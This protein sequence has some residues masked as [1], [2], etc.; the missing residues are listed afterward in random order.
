MVNKVTAAKPKGWRSV[1]FDAVQRFDEPGGRGPEDAAIFG[2][3][4]IA[5][6]RRAFDLSWSALAFAHFDDEHEIRVTREELAKRILEGAAR[7]ERRIPVLSGRALG[8][9]EPRS[10]RGSSGGLPW[11]SS[12]Y[13]S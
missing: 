7:G 10:A 11:R 5:V 2:P 13:D 1:M 12:R 3:D 9:L 6:M 8:A 4:V